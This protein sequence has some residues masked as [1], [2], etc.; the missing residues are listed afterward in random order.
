[1][2]SRGGAAIVVKM[3]GPP[4]L[5]KTDEIGEIC[6]HAPSTASSYFGLDGLSAQRFHISPLDPEERS[7]GPNHYV[8]SGLIGFLG[9]VV[10]SF[11]SDQLQTLTFRKDS[12]LWSAPGPRLWLSR[13]GSMEPTISLPLY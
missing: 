6:L 1:M 11:V 13:D 8:R 5:C 4:K 3:S 7:L 2:C 9:P 10:G 12:S